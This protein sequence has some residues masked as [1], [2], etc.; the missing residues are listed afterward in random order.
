MWPSLP[1]LLAVG[2]ALAAL[3]T[4]C[5][6]D[7]SGEGRAVYLRNCAGC[8]GRDGAGDGPQA[9]GLPVPPANL[10]GLA[11]AG[12]GVFP[13]EDVMAAIYGYRGKDY[14]ALMPA[15]GPLFDGPTVDWTAPDG[16]VIETPR[17]LVTLTRYLET[18]QDI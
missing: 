16:T 15:F 3:T 7:R 14:A 5:A 9:E 11:A 1:A 18:L 12:G 6:P 17:A 4:A 10:R 13:A 2:A 8:H